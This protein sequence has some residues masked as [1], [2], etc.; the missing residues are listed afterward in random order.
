MFYPFLVVLTCRH[1]G[2]CAGESKLTMSQNIYYLQQLVS[3][4]L[5]QWVKLLVRT[6]HAPGQHETV[7]G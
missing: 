1:G 4:Y 7:R 6:V 3:L 5:D 2:R